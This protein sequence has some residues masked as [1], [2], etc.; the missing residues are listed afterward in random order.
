MSSVN[1]RTAMLVT[2]GDFDGGKACDARTL[3]L[4]LS[5]PRAFKSC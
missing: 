5:R 3:A 4:A 2:A 1:A